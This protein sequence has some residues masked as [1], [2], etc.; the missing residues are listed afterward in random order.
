MLG[1][2]AGVFKYLRSTPEKVE[3]KGEWESVRASADV[4]LC[5]MVF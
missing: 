2:A 4:Q 5:F 3:S 1:D